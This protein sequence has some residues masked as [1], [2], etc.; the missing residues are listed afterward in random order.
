MSESEDFV[1]TPHS[2]VWGDEDD[3]WADAVALLWGQLENEIGRPAVVRRREP[4]PGTKG[5]LDSVMLALAAPGAFASS[6]AVVEYWLQR[7]SDRSV[8]IR[9]AGA[10]SSESVTI[11]AHDVRDGSFAAMMR[12][13]APIPTR[14]MP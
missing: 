6:I 9:R 8:T 1:L 4:V 3:R 2:S 13:L 5:T 10:P 12:S 7:A 14:D 11:T